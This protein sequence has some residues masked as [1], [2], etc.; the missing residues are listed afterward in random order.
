MNDYLHRL[1]S[2]LEVKN[3]ENVFIVSA[4]RIQFNITFHFNSIIGD[5][6]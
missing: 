6:K 4:A 3:I 5:I 2:P 1:V